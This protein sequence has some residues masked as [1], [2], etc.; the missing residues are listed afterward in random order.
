M[1][2]PDPA[3]LKAACLALCSRDASLARA[4]DETGLPQWRAS[5][6]VY[7]TLARMIAFQQISTSAGAA[8]WGRLE[9][10]LGEVSAPA[11]LA[12]SEEEI[13]ACGFSRPKAGHLRAIAGAVESGT[14]DLDFA[15]RAP[16]DAARS[17]LT[18]VRGIGPWTAE[19]FLL[20]A[21]GQLD[22]FPTAD[23]GLMESYR[24]LSGAQARH[25][26]KAFSAL[27]DDW[28]PYRGVAAH[29]LWAW[30]NAQRAK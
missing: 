23:I 13:R 4:Y 22:A 11:L 28:R 14:L 29:L 8:I 25:D 9:T 27:A 15:C 26:A 5:A 12:L 17:H 20:Y 7:A 19:L 21:G 18:A 3:A 6:P 16:M 24:Q 10:R 1:S 30:I 2:A